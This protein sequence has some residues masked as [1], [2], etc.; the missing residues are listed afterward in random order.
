MV[1]LSRS[2]TAIAPHTCMLLLPRRYPTRNQRTCRRTLR[3]VGGDAWSE[4]GYTLCL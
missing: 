2:P 4:R 1:A 3:I